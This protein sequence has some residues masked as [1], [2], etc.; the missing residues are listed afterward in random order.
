[1]TAPV[2]PAPARGRSRG[3]VLGLEPP[4]D[5][6]LR[7]RKV[8]T[9]SRTHGTGKYPSWKVNRMIQWSCEGQLNA[10]RLLDASPCVR[11]F[12][13]QPL[14]VRYVLDGEERLHYPAIAVVRQHTKELWDV[15]TDIY[16]KEVARRTEVM[17]SGLPT[18]GYAYRI[19]QA[20]SLAAE[21]MLSNVLKV[22]RYGRNDIPMLDRERLRQWL[23]STPRVTWGAVQ[24]GA[25]GSA[26]RHHVCRLL[27]E[28]VL[29]FDMQHPLDASTL[30]TGDEPRTAD[31][32]FAWT[33]RLNAQDPSP[34]PE[35]QECL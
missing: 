4:K 31:T 24:G 18:F 3:P 28:G 15:E 5:G 6:Q 10:F 8:V 22:L 26:G 17:S 30:L 1:M 21:P 7:S 32:N 14:V 27:L 34:G 25:L 29:C 16:A 2:A 35:A 11:R 19:L 23:A 12:S 13:E 33:A 9:R 20:D